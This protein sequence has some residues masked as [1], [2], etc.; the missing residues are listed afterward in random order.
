M[1]ISRRG[2]G[3]AE[4][5]LDIPAEGAE[6]LSLFWAFPQ[7][8]RRDWFFLGGS[9]RGRREAEFILGIPAEGAERLGGIGEIDSIE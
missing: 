9:R 3:E 7:R 2:R 8:A 5:I 1:G 4:F 6:R